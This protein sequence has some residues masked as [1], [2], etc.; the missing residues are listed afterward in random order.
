MCTVCAGVPDPPLESIISLGLVMSRKALA[1]PCGCF[2]TYT[3][4]FTSIPLPQF[5]SN[6]PKCGELALKGRSRGGF[7]EQLR[8]LA[9][10]IMIRHSSDVIADDS[11]PG[12][13]LG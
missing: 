10:Q 12:R 6:I 2:E 11:V 7:S 13:M 8:V 9:E 1:V 3:S 5:R 4:G